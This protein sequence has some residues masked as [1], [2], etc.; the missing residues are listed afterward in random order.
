MS[1]LSVHVALS[2]MDVQSELLVHRQ[3]LCPIPS[4]QVNKDA[5]THRET[6][7]L[8]AISNFREEVI[9]LAKK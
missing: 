3:V 4:K 7:D 1:V 8:S 6:W 5:M 2:N 9:W